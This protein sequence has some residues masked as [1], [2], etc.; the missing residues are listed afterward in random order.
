[1]SSPPPG[2]NPEASQLHGGT[3]APIAKVMGGGGGA[4]DGYNETQSLL[5]GGTDAPIVKMTG[6]GPEEDAAADKAEAEATAAELAAKQAEAAAAAAEAKA[7]GHEEDQNIA[8]EV[9]ATSLT[10]RKTRE[11]A[12]AARAAATKARA[13]ADSTKVAGPRGIL[14]GGPRV[15][16]PKKASIA[17]DLGH[18][19]VEGPTK[20]ENGAGPPLEK[21]K[22]PVEEPAPVTSM[23][24]M[25]VYD[26]K[27]SEE[28]STE[29]RTFLTTFSMQTPGVKAKLIELID[30]FKTRSKKKLVRYDKKSNPQTAA[31]P[32]VA[33]PKTVA[34]K[35][36]EVLPP[37]T[38]N[39]IIVPPIKGNYETFIR[40]VEFLYAN[41]I[42]DA[43]DNLQHAVLIFMAPFFSHEGDQRRLL[44]S[45]LTLQ[46]KNPDT[47]FVLQN[48]NE[49]ARPIGTALYTDI[50]PGD[51]LFLN[52]LNPSYILFPKKVGTYDGLL[53]SSAAGLV[54]TFPKI[55]NKGFLPVSTLLEKKKSVFSFNVSGAQIDETFA[56]YL[57]ILSQ[58]D[59]TPLPV[60]RGD[61]QA[62]GS[63]KT[64]FDLTDPGPFQISGGEDIYILRFETNKRPLLCTALM[65]ESDKF[66]GAESD[67]A[68]YD[69]PTIE[70]YVGGQKWKFRDPRQNKFSKSLNE[71]ASGEAVPE[72]RNPVVLNWQRGIFSSSEASFLNHLNLSPLLLGMIF[73]SDIWK[74]ELAKFLN[75]LVTTDCFEDTDILMKGSCQ[76]TRAFLNTV[77]NYLFMND[78]IKDEELDVPPLKL[79]PLPHS[80]D[81]AEINWPPELEEIEQDEFQKENLGSVDVV[82]NIKTNTYFMDLI[83]IHKKS[84]ERSTRRL[85]LD[86]EKTE[87][88][89]EENDVI[90]AEILEDLKDDHPDFLFI[91]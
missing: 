20:T 39:I 11:R 51:G 91:Y 10:A 34:H 18:G 28:D 24:Q 2:Y 5:Q 53:F 33:A 72:T 63:L 36:V 1:M 42:I 66:Q 89:P 71:I 14:R 38:S 47:V 75:N 30:S 23:I 81:S 40:S 64:V 31:I 7:V 86:R 80:Q 19:N 55:T 58:N 57:T 70:V 88:E 22:A 78:S 74:E 43:N 37:T 60:T 76:D 65:D 49:H 3:D 77:Y 16:P 85:R 69:V 48:D 4:P 62:C 50:P 56:K 87:A 82:T 59:T 54:G 73:K 21:E 15:G 41:D 25:E 45:F 12:T 52:Y 61:V 26:P 46:E 17:G 84:F 9:E 83:V 13:L 79:P 44:Y 32:T 6:G 35:I 68:F 27:F 29:I 67:P 90:F 8:S